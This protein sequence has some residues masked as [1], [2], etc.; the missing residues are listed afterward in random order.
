MRIAVLEDDISQ[1][2]L[3]S[4]WLEMAG[5]RAHAFERGEEL[6]RA[7]EKETFDALL[8][9]WNV[10]D[11]SGLEVL[12]RVRQQVGSRIPV[13]FS[14][15]RTDEADV[16]L[17]LRQGADGY[18]VKPLRRL[19]LLARVEAVTRRSVVEGSQAQHLEVGIFRVDAAARR[20][21]RNDQPLDLT[22]KDFDLAVFFLRNVGRLL[23]RGHL[24][25][26]VWNAKAVVSSRTLDTHVS[27]VR[28]KLL[29]VPEHGWR[30]MAVYGYGYRLEQLAEVAALRAVQISSAPKER[31]Q[32]ASP[33]LVSEET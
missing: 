23:S 10:P 13:L 11:V 22:A 17:A 21:L 24:R 26:S 25:E 19:E 14:T 2:E 32:P 18:L 12:K 9:D 28:K 4:R 33:D 6:L 27:R 3:I 5:H 20:L 29:L 1:M 7:L 8:L 31:A 15:A 30:L 16:V